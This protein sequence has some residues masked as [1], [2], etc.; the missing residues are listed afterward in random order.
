[1]N[2]YLTQQSIVAQLLSTFSGAALPYDAQDL[3]EVPADYNRAIARPIVYVVFTGSTADTSMTTRPIVQTRRLSFNLE[4][5]ARLLYGPNG[6]FAVRDVVEQCLIGFVPTNA[7]QI[8]LKSDE[9]S[10]TENAIWVHILKIECECRLVQKEDGDPIIV[11]S[12]QELI[13]ND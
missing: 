6:L 10:Q 13:N 1:M 5:Q 11:P 8:Y 4:I 2:I 7:R 9:I 12:F 3:P